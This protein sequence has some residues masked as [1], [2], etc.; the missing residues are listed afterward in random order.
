MA[1]K[2]HHVFRGRATR[3]FTVEVS[4]DE[5]DW[6]T[7]VTGTFPSMPESECDDTRF[8]PAEDGMSTFRFVR[9]TAVSHH[10]TVAAALNFIKPRQTGTCRMCNRVTGNY[11]F[12]FLYRDAGCTGMQIIMEDIY[13]IVFS[14]D[15]IVRAEGCS[16]DWGS[17]WVSSN[18]VSSLLTLSK[19]VVRGAFC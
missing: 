5:S 17:Q 10:G 11:S 15:D 13:N 9:F 4:M 1:G 18:T 8:F 3:D 12:P 7:A 6:V 19:S 2:I 16:S 14:A